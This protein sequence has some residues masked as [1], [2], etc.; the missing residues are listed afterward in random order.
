MNM[1]MD[2]KTLNTV[3]EILKGKISK[4]PNR[5]EEANGIVFTMNQK[6]S[7]EIYEYFNSRGV[8]YHDLKDGSFYTETIMSVVEFS[9]LK[10]VAKYHKVA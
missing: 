10:Y 8:E 9:N 7:E 6:D 1:N 3:E 5:F 4:N 2:S